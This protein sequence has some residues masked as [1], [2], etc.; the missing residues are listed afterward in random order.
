M[1]TNW[2]SHFKFFLYNAVTFNATDNS[3]YYQ[4]MVN[5]IALA[6]PGVKA[7]QD[8]RLEISIWRRKRTKLKYILLNKSKM[9]TAWLHNHM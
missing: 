1:L 6:G 7:L 3:P 8:T 5:T 4:V 2:K 9:V